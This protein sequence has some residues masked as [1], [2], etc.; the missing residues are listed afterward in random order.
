MNFRQNL[1]EMQ[2]RF[3]LVGLTETASLILDACSGR[4][5]QGQVRLCRPIHS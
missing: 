5:F 1:I 4:L 3:T 2:I